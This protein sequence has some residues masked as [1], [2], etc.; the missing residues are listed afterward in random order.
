MAVDT[1]AKRAAVLSHGRAFMRGTHPTGA[2]DAIYRGSV[3]HSYGG[4]GYEDEVVF[5]P[6]YGRLDEIR[7]F[8]LDNGYSGSIADMLMQWLAA[9]G[10]STGGLLDRWKDFL[11]DAGITAGSV[12]DRKLQYYISLG[13]NNSSALNDVELQA[14]HEELPPT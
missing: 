2:D 12:L 8:L 6:Q 11:N 9:Q 14:W 1:R 7:Q 10:N 4:N 13:A 3:G 5:G